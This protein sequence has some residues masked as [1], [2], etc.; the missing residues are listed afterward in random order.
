MTI[1][2]KV[3][4]NAKKVRLKEENGALKLYITQPPIEGKANKAVCAYFA[5]LAGI[6][7]SAV[8]IL[9]GKKQRKKTLAIDVNEKQWRDALSRALGD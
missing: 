2:V 7:K 4:P 6:S 3:V 1:D 8:D 9:R 5:K